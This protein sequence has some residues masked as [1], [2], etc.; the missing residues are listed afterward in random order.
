[1]NK[2]NYNRTFYDWLFDRRMLGNRLDDPR[3]GLYIEVD[4]GINPWQLGYIGRGLFPSWRFY[5]DS[6]L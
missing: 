2:L 1:M 4:I 5:G 6:L 3:I